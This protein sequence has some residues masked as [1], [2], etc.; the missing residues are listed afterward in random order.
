MSMLLGV[1][2]PTFCIFFAGYLL[3]KSRKLDIKSISTLTVYIL[4]PAL[5]F[6]TFYTVEL[7]LQYLLMAV[8][9]IVLLVILIVINKLYIKIRKFPKDVE[10]ALILS[11]AFMNAGNYGA[12]IILFAYG[13]VGFAY[14]VSFMVLQ[15]MIM[16]F[17]GVY[18]AARG[19]EGVSAAIKFVFKMPLTYTLLVGILF[20]VMSINVPT[21][22][23]SA[24]NLVANAAIPA[25][26]LVLGM[27]LA[28]LKIDKLLDREKVT[29]GVVVRMVVS[30]LLAVLILQF[31]PFDPLLQKVLIVSTAMPAAVTTTMYA[32][33]F[34]TLPT[35]VSSITFVTTVVSAVSL[36]IILVLLG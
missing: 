10:S 32:I 29:Y 6:Q 35:L 25:A 16:N 7:N 2:L 36:S 5:V 19:A 11:T 21:G 27:Q 4:T 1:I 26:M 22:I 18:Y 15:S 31:L 8:F 17:F 3:Q 28:E 23:L 9:A 34:N 30:P 24:V 13:E 14:A 12:P 33:Q 20:N